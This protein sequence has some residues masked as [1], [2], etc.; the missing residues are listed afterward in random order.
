MDLIGKHVSTTGKDLP[1]QVLRNITILKEICRT[2]K[3]KCLCP[4]E[5]PGC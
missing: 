3:K 4:G 5:Q 1:E 2:H